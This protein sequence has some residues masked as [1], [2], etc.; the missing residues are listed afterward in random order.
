MYIPINVVLLTSLMEAELNSGLLCLRLLG[1]VNDCLCILPRQVLNLMYGRGGLLSI[2]A[3]L[4]L[5]IVN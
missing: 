1:I 2:H 3:R 4:T 5:R